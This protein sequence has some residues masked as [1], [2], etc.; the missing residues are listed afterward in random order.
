MLK[1]LLIKDCLISVDAMGC[2]GDIA[3]HI[4]AGKGNNLLAVKNNQGS[5]CQ[6][7]EDSFRFLKPEGYDEDIDIGHGRIETGRYAIMTDLVYIEEPKR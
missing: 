1:S 4:V 6:N 2:Q 3:E 7:I 5:L